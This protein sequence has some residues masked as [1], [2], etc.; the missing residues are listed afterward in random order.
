MLEEDTASTLVEFQRGGTPNTTKNYK[1]THGKTRTLCGEHEDEVVSY[2]CFDCE[3]CICAECGING[4]HRYHVA[5]K[6][7]EAYYICKEKTD[8]ILGKFKT[9]NEEIEEQ[10][11]N[12]FNSKI[13]IT[14]ETEVKKEEVLRTFDGLRRILDQNEREI[15]NQVEANGQESISRLNDQLQGTENQYRNT[16]KNIAELRSSLESLDQ[17]S[18]V[19]FFTEHKKKYTKDLLS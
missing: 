6:L 9:Q 4:L 10:I 19:R 7:A 5:S 12:L 1:N 8:R 16:E 14:E 2:F 13:S 3:E 18:F 15:V 11:E 17:V